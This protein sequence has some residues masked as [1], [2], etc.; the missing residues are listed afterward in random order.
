MDSAVVIA[1]CSA[2]LAGAE[3]QVVLT[4]GHHAL[5]KETLPLPPN[6]HYAP[7]V[8]GLA[9]AE[10]SD[11]LIHH[12]GYGSCQTGRHT[13]TPAV[14][15][16]TYSERESNA[17]RI[18]A[19]GAGEFVLPVK[20]RW[21][22]KRVDMSTLQAKISAVLSDP[23]YRAHAGVMREKLLAYGGAPEAAR[24]IDA[25]VQKRE[26]PSAAQPAHPTDAAIYPDAFRA[27]RQEIHF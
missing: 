21:G 14:I 20:Q 17:R 10:R 18:A 11:L 15:M 26:Q 23:A 24:L 7:F 13:G 2:A 5:P 19:V 27:E 25:F 4:T 12:G 3:V 1:A 16:P 9:M 8:P 22:K 6:F